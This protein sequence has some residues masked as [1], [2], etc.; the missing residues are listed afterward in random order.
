M[1]LNRLFIALVILLGSAALT[2]A[3]ILEKIPEV[4]IERE[5]VVDEDGLKQWKPFEIKC[6]PCHGRGTHECLG[7]KDRD[8]PNCT[9]CEG[10]KRGACRYCV[11][12][13]KLLDPIEAMVCAFCRGSGWYDC[14]QCGGSGKI[15]ESDGKGNDVTI[16]CGA[17][18]KVGR[19]VC[20]VCEGERS[21]PSVRVKRGSPSEAEH[22]D[23]L[24]MQETLGEILTY[25]E[26]FEPEGR[27][28]KVRKSLEKD[29]KKPAKAF[30]P[31]AGML[32][33]METVQKGIEKVGAKYTNFQSR[34]DHQCR[35]LRDRTIYTLRFQIRVLELC[36]ARAEFNENVK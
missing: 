24:K 10:E 22:D 29:L 15:N 35:V 25:L 17:C 30:K 3:Q 7:C 11:G 31:V 32:E 33:L 26:E 13:G 19:Y 16:N 2:P 36:A 5:L 1:T 21:I 14:G 28:S 12:T 8:I 18:K 4:K 27:A 34:L 23:I 6:E 9:E 20:V